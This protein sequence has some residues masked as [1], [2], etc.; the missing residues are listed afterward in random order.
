MIGCRSL[1]VSDIVESAVATIQN[2]LMLPV[3]V[4]V[5][6]MTKRTDLKVRM[7]KAGVKMVDLA[8][9]IGIPVSRLSN[10]LNGYAPMPNDVE[11][12]V[13]DYLKDKNG[14]AK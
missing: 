4:I 5:I 7:V 6:S 13:M 3:C 2:L 9:G 10:W 11:I 12:R 14:T 8:L 1:K